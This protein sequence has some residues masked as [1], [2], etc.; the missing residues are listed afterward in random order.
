MVSTCFLEMAGSAYS[1]MAYQGPVASTNPYWDAEPRAWVP[2]IW[3]LVGDWFR[4]KVI[5]VE[6]LLLLPHLGNQKCYPG[7]HP[8][9]PVLVFD[10]SFGQTLGGGLCLNKSRRIKIQTY[11][12]KYVGLEF[13]RWSEGWSGISLLCKSVGRATVPGACRMSTLVDCEILISIVPNWNKVVALWVAICVGSFWHNNSTILHRFE[14]GVMEQDKI[15]NVF[16]SQRHQNNKSYGCG[17]I[18]VDVLGNKKKHSR[19]A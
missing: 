17:C 18:N 3:A 14:S 10:V 15:E 19:A 5:R 9:N 13:I 12:Y 4:E 16:A 11:V 8:R 2:L 7:S 6:L 1:Q